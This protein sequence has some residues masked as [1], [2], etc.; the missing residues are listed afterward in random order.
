MYHTTGWK[1]LNCH[2]MAWLV[3]GK[4]WSPDTTFQNRME[5]DTTLEIWFTTITRA[6]LARLAAAQEVEFRIWQDERSYSAEVMQDLKDF[7][8]ALEKALAQPQGAQ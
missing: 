6:D 3:D 2:D 5:G 1:Y 7:G 8:P 4:S